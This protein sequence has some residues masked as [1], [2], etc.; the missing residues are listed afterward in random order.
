[1]LEVISPENVKKI[2]DFNDSMSSTSKK[3]AL[4]YTPTEKASE[5]PCKKH[6]KVDALALPVKFNIKPAVW[7]YIP[8]G[9]F[10][11]LALKENT[12]KKKD[13]PDLD[14]PPLASLNDKTEYGPPRIFK[15]VSTLA[16]F[17]NNE[18]SPIVFKCFQPGC[19]FIIKDK[20]TFIAHLDAKHFK[21]PW[22]GMCTACVAIVHVPPSSIYDEMEHVLWH[23]RGG[24]Q[25]QV[26]H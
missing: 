10:G 7:K 24:F 16:Y 23:A 13:L 11:F 19:P 20:E 2:Q 25:A 3:R 9:F 22:S 17:K 1:M 5:P 6:I 14:F 12:E 15:L 18:T 8:G 26:A 21:A 4:E